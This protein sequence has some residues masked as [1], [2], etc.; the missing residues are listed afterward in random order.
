MFWPKIPKL[1]PGKVLK[2]QNKRDHLDRCLLVRFPPPPA[3]VPVCSFIRP[4]TAVQQKVNI[5]NP[6]NSPPY[7]SGCEDVVALDLFFGC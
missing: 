2:C 4:I 5:R 6:V 7:D 3:N 1:V